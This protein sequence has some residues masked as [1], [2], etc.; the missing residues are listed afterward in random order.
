MSSGG[1]NF[2][3][4]MDEFKNFGP[5]TSPNRPKTSEMDQFLEASQA[6]L[7]EIKARNGIE[8][9]NTFRYT[10]LGVSSR[11]PTFEDGSVRHKTS[12]PTQHAQSTPIQ[13][14]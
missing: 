12:M 13:D 14:R 4:G 10:P 8:Q 6:R 3:L 9:E 7:N 5:M 11:V 2:T 1:I